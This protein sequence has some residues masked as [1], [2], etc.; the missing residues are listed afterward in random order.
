[1]LFGS[2]GRG[3]GVGSGDETV[4]TWNPPSSHGW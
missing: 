4:S 3:G 1:M 2:A